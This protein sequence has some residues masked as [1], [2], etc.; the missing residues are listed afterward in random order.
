[1]RR[2]INKIITNP[3]LS[4]SAIMIVGSNSASAINY[5]YHLI[6]GRLL[7]PSLYGEFASLISV[8]GLLGM[9][10]AAVG[11]V[12]V[13]QISSAKNQ[14]EISNLISWFKTKV[15]VV[16]LL[17]SLLIL[18]SSPFITSFLH[19][20]KISYLL[21]I[22]ISFLFSLQAGFNRF[23]LQGLLRFKEFVITILIENTSKLLISIIFILVGFAVSGALTGIVIA[24]CLGFFLTNY[25]LRTKHKNA[26]GISPKLKPMFLLTI[27]ILIQSISTTS[28]YTMDVVLVKHFFSSHN[29]GIYASLS[30]LGKIIF[31]G[32]G[33]INAVMFP[34]VAKQSSRG[35]NYRQVLLYSFAA[36]VIFAV[37]V[38]FF[39]KLAPELAIYLLFG[40]LY[41]ESSKL[42]I[43]FGIFIS[44]FTLSFLLI[45]FGISLG[46][47][48]I[49]VFPLI[50]AALQI[51]LISLFHETILTVVIVSIAVNALLLL[52]LLI[53]LSFEK[54]LIYGKNISKRDKFDLNNRPGI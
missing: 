19:I 29:A 21:L 20:D 8:I 44:L 25:Y 43:W 18:I 41:L 1:M 13:K 4:G 7:G 53:Y 42:L 2:Y 37:G 48:I 23:I 30:T 36:T 33:P 26:S 24:S 11:L 39:Y 27:P 52:T 35:E 22:S 16:S 10:P 3:F 49:V 47:N 17:F 9:I 38:C 6:V 15:F 28:I 14:V 5:L 31:F 32:A 54:G 50:F 46:K 34:L 45:N 40:S 12:I 51:I